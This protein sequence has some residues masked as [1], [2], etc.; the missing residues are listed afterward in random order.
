MYGFPVCKHISAL[1]NS[2]P[3]PYDIFAPFP[4]LLFFM[5]PLLASNKICT[6]IFR[7]YKKR[8][9]RNDLDYFK[10]TGIAVLFFGW[11]Y[12]TLVHFPFY[13]ENN[14]FGEFL[15]ALFG[16]IFIDTFSD[17]V[18]TGVIVKRILKVI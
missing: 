13:L 4:T 11:V 7:I 14:F 8:L 17:L 15:E 2:L 10:S 9:S 5:V 16:A 1:I 3:S 6:A 18:R 12:V